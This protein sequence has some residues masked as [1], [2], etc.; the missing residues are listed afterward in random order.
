MPFLQTMNA[1]KEG[2]S[3]QRRVLKRQIRFQ[4]LLVQLFL[5]IWMRQKALDFR[6][7]HETAVH[8]RIVIRFDAKVIPRAEKLLFLSILDY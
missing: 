2:F 3:V 6:T 7:K 1:F 4:C 8:L 5:E